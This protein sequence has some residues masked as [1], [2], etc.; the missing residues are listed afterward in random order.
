MQ[1]N[2][3]LAKQ[4]LKAIGTFNV[5]ELDRL[6][7]DDVHYWVAGM[8]RD[9]FIPRDALLQALEQMGK[10]VFASPLEFT[11]HD[12]TSEGGRVAIEAT[13]SAK[14]CNG[15]DYHNVYHF[16]FEFADGKLIVG[17]EYADTKLLEQIG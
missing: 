1:T 16:L 12:T 14:L 10:Q 8:P 4:L 13:S 3:D 2:L 7:A 15:N 11:I 6:L 9:Q 17:R 5:A